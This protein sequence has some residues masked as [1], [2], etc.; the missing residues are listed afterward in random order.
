MDVDSIIEG[1]KHNPLTLTLAENVIK[2]INEQIAYL[3]RENG[4]CEEEKKDFS[5]LAK[6]A[7]IALYAIENTYL[8]GGNIK[9]WVKSLTREQLN[10]AQEAI[11]DEIKM[12]NKMS[13]V[14]VYVARLPYGKTRGFLSVQSAM[15]YFYATLP[16]LL[17]RARKENS[18]IHEDDICME[19]TR[20]HRAELND[21][22]HDDI[23]DETL[24][25]QALWDA[26][27]SPI[28]QAN[29]DSGI[30]F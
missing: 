22:I 24:R 13:L 30:I 23:N 27:Y 9:K 1:A 6:G 20:C 26:F 12:R 16:N 19:S 14:K 4:G 25:S 29:E 2:K 3:E 7:R 21:F 11:G 28:K 8:D 15:S 10:Y 18:I 17:E 5:R